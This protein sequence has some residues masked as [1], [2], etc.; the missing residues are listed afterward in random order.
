MW[1]LLKDKNKFVIRKWQ[2]GKFLRLPVKQYKHIREDEKQLKEFVDR[3]NA[4]ERVKTAVKWKHAFIS[5]ELLDEYKE[6]LMAQIPNQENALTNYHY[7]ISYGLN[8]FVGRLNIENP[9]DW[10]KVH[11]TLWA[12]FLTS[13]DAPRSVK[14]KRTIVQEMNRFN[15]VAS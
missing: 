9:I 1:S 11:K 15:K 14:T 10:F 8:F 13:K 4:P 2:N 3:L 6:F 7:L 12:K 5:P